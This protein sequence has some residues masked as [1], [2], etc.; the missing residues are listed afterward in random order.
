METIFRPADD[1]GASVALELRNFI[2][3]LIDGVACLSCKYTVRGCGLLTKQ[4]NTRTYMS[5]VLINL[6]NI[7]AFILVFEVT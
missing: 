7:R 6:C 3:L 2:I 4:L 5:L 1:I